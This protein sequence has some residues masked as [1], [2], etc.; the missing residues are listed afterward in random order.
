MLGMPVLQYIGLSSEN[1]PEVTKKWHHRAK[2]CK[3]SVDR[4]FWPVQV[5]F[6]A[7]IASK[8]TLFSKK[9]NFFDKIDI[10]SFSGGNMVR[11]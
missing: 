7:K 8:V 11:T 4:G 9:V 10:F 5:I 1:W 3:N 6:L 2:N